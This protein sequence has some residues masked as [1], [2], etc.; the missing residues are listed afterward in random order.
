MEYFW[1]KN[2]W[3]HGVISREVGDDPVYILRN[4]DS[5]DNC[6]GLEVRDFT[7]EPTSYSK[8][9]FIIDYTD[10]LK[11]PLAETDSSG[12]VTRYYVWVGMRLLCHI[13]A[14]GTTRYYHADELGNTIALTD[15]SGNLTDEFAYTPYGKV[16]NRTGT[17][18]TPFL[19]LGGG[20]VYYDADIDLHF[21]LHR[22]YSSNLRRFISTDP[23]GIDG[24]VNLYAYGN[25]N[26]LFFVDPYG[27]CAESYNASLSWRNAV[28]PSISEG[29][30]RMRSQRALYNQPLLLGSSFNAYSDFGN[31]IAQQNAIDYITTIPSAVVG[32]WAWGKAASVF[33]RA[34]KTTTALTKYEPWPR[35]P[36]SPHT[37]GFLFG[38]RQVET[39][40]T[41]QIFSR[42]GK[43][44][45]S[46]VAPPGT[47]ISS[48]GLPAGYQ[49]PESLWKVTK[50]FSME[51]GLSA[52]WQGSSGLGIQNKLPQSIDSLWESG[53][54]S[55][56]QNW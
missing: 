38:A 24:D 55:P 46:Y 32:E 2:G 47:S 10:D 43:T 35:P 21:T 54:L 11:R 36:N 37:D 34:P 16:C 8:T 56:V 33:R 14:D 50:P 41:G 7:V 9:Y 19:W 3:L 30:H 23:L 39:A 25:L 31:Q 51:S 20:G 49:G 17:T 1:L 15:E 40:Q 52:P 48:R 44:S 45:G 28:G 13:E 22:V 4:Y 18:E 42:I 53:Y 5:V 26:P 27:L 6:V 12:T 29:E